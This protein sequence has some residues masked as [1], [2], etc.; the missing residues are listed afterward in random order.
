MSAI[1][2]QS[3]WVS[4]GDLILTYEQ[5]L[6]L[7]EA[8]SFE[9]GVTLRAGE[10]IVGPSTLPA[11]AEIEGQYVTLIALFGGIGRGACA[12]RFGR[13]GGYSDRGDGRQRAGR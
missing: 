10:S 12:D 11:T 3:I 5:N 6:N 8:Y 9:G 4:E 1:A 7:V 13:A 2:Y